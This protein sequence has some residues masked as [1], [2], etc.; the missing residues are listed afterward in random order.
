[1]TKSGV[2]QPL[3]HLYLQ[4]ERPGGGQEEAAGGQPAVSGEEGGG[5]LPEVQHERAEG[6][7]RRGQQVGGGEHAGTI[8]G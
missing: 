7:E 1:M 3:N 8:S 2:T 5:G 6:A 4:E